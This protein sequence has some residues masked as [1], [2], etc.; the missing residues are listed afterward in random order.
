MT[1]L[2][3]VSCHAMD[4]EHVAYLMQSKEIDAASFCGYD[5]DVCNSRDLL[6]IYWI[7]IRLGRIACFLKGHPNDNHC[8]CRYGARALSDQRELDALA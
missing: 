5:I 2:L 3:I 7:Y 6:P 1:F 4:K 8:H